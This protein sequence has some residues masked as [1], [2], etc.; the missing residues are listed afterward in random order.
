MK[1][2]ALISVSLILIGCQSAQYDSRVKNNGLIPSNYGIDHDYRKELDSLSLNVDRENSQNDERWTVK[3]EKDA[4]T[5][6]VD[7]TASIQS[8]EGMDNI[9]SVSCNSKYKEPIVS[10]LAVDRIVTG[11][12][13]M[14]RLDSKKPFTSKVMISRTPSGSAFIV[15]GG[16]LEKVNVGDNLS[17]RY[18]EYSKGYE[19]LNFSMKNYVD[20]YA[21]VLRSCGLK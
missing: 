21:E 7:T 9:L 1:K 5:D 17:V 6:Y 10:I 16:F 15:R 12:S 4:M 14:F 3:K 8:K 20:S 13:V 2:L 18:Q 19:D 11:D